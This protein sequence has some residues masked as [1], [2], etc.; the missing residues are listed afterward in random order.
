MAAIDDITKLYVGYYDRAPDPEGLNYWIGQANT[1]MSLLAIA[2]SF[3][4]QVESTRLYSFLA[5]PLTSSAD[6]FLNS[7]YQNLFNR[8]IDAEGLNYWKGE[9]ANGKPVG[10]MIVDIISGAQGADKTIV[11]NKTTVGK[12]YVS[13]ADA[14]NSGGFRLPDARQV[15]DGVNA[16][17]ASVTSAQTLASSLAREDLSLTFNDPTGTLAPF[18][19]AISKSFHL[20]WDMWE[21]F[22]TRHAP[23]EV[24]INFDPGSGSFLALAS[25]SFYQTGDN[26]NGQPVLQG[27]VA[28][29]LITGTDQN[30]LEPDGE[31]SIGDNPSQLVFR[32]SLSEPVPFEKFDAVSVFAHEIGHLLGFAGGLQG[33]GIAIYDRFISFGA[34]AGPKAV[35]ANGGVAVALAAGSQSHLADNT[36][37]MA[38]ALTNG[39][40][41]AVE[42][43]HIAILQDMGLPVSVLGAGG[44]V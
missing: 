9:L 5:S 18:Q 13:E 35:A 43:L 19:T 20:A 8:P 16:T 10:R 29:E 31:V 14:P 26:F 28:R 22:F 36:D 39:Q 17:T 2:Q 38:T 34:F 41:R 21:M 30:G 40:S 37:L 33:G 7:V 6:S 12:F 15:L 11:D 27:A 24:E 4:V 42:P 32:A 3:S 23:V 1:G 25:S 44:L